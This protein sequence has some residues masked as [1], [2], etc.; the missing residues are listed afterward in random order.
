[1][2]AMDHP[3]VSVLMPVYNGC[4]APRAGLIKRLL[5]RRRRP[6]VQADIPSF[7][8][9]SIESVLDQTFEDFE[10]VIVDD[11][12]MDGTP[13]VLA[14]YAARDDRIRVVRSRANRGVA[15]ALNLGLRQC[16]APLVARQ[17]ADDLSTVTRL[18]VQK[19]FMDGRPR[20]A[21]CGTGAYV[22]NAEGKLMFEVRHVCANEEVRRFLAGA[23]CP[24]VHG[25]VMFRKECVQ[26]LGG[27]SEQERFRHAEDYEMWVRLAGK[28]VLENVPDRSLYFHRQHDSKVGEVHRSRQERATERILAM[29]RRGLG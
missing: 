16:R 15:A 8:R 21:M 12:S 28:Y 3:A 2:T 26:E 19:A 4:S 9:L 5:R 17:D 1:M 18:E 22:I 25:S 24:F 13:A 20:T 11:G 14:Q 29:A 6:G 10:F 23:G 7:L 27:Y